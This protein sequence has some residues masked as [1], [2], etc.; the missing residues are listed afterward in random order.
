MEA[1]LPPPGGHAAGHLQ[2]GGNQE[3]GESCSSDDERSELMQQSGKLLCTSQ[4]C[5]KTPRSR[6]WHHECA[7]M[8]LAATFC[9]CLRILSQEILAILC[10]L[11]L[12]GSAKGRKTDS[13][14]ANNRRAQKAFRER[15][16]VFMFHMVWAV[17]YRQGTSLLGLGC[18]PAKLSSTFLCTSQIYM[19]FLL[20]VY[21]QVGG[22][23]FMRD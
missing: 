14:R 17:H 9:G 1:A 5:C 6:F 8:A 20:P 11:C 7:L 2:K 22:M 18:T 4:S 15:Q 12:A 16:K 21:N 10:C 13:W 3:E 23:A 19:A